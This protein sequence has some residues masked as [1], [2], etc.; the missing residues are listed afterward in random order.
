VTG[1]LACPKRQVVVLTSVELLFQAT[2]L[3]EHRPPHDGEVRHVRK[4]QQQIGRPLRFEIRIEP[5]PGGIDLVL[6]GIDQVDEL[7]TIDDRSDLGECAWASSSSWS[8]K[9]M[10]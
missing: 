4:A 9:A 2:H 6:V 1:L 3:V 10:N 5:L 8:K 7:V